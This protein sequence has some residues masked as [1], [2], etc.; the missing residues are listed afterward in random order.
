MRSFPFAAAAVTYAMYLK[1]FMKALAVYL[2]LMSGVIVWLHLAAEDTAQSRLERAPSATASINWSGTPQGAATDAGNGGQTQQQDPQDS[3]ITAPVPPVNGGDTDKKDQPAVALIVMDMG[4]AAKATERAIKTMPPEVT[5]AFSPYTDDLGFWL[6]Q[7]ADRHHQTLLALPMEPATYPRDDPGPRA[8]LTRNS[9]EMNRQNL[10]WALKQADGYAGYI[11]FMGDRMLSD[12]RRLKP[13]FRDLARTGLF[14]IE[15]GADGSSV[16]ETVA[17]E[18]DLVFARADVVL[19]E[20][21][22]AAGIREGLL[23]LEKIAR[24]KGAAIGVLF[25]Y[26]LVLGTVDDWYM[27]LEEK[28]LRLAPAAEAVEIR[29]AQ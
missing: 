18:T 16:G 17:R 23:R 1:K 2:I 20:E 14:F 5:L 28:K 13:L 10:E 22:D 21:L 19:G 3:V 29:N 7:S 27:T 24:G 9:M 11:N 25:P 6:G 12:R 26:P 15:Q 4:I 8:M